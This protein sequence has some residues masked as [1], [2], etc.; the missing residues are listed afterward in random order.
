VTALFI[1]AKYEEIMAPSVANFLA[2][3][4]GNYGEKDILDA[5]KYTLRTLDW[6]MSYPNPIHCLRKASKADGYDLAVSVFTTFSYLG[7]FADK[8]HPVCCLV[9]HSR[10]ILDRDLHP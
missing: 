9:S 7:A 1:A 2:S 4:E 3:A 10:Q 5:E 6:N 8:P